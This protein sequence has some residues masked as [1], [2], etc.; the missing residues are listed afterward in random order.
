MR[1]IKPRHRKSQVVKRGINARKRPKSPWIR[2]FFRSLSYIAVLCFSIG[3][4]AWLW[5][6]DWMSGATQSSWQ[7]T[8]SHLGKAGLRVEEV[9]LQGREHE[10]AERITRV[11]GIKRGAPILAINLQD[12]RERLEALSWVR[13]ASVERH[14]PNTVRIKIVERQPMALWQRENKLA[15]ID[16]EGVII[17]R[18]R[19]ERFRHLLVVVGK[20]APAHT[21]SL[22]RTLAKDL[23][24][25]KR[26]AAAVRIG[27]RRWN[28]QMD[29]GI[30]VRLPEEGTEAAWRRF[31]KLERKYELLKQDLLSIDLRMPGQLIV[32]TRGDRPGLNRKVTHRKG[33][34]T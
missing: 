11:I 23:D 3:G 8:F 29:N 10:S 6:S 21:A 13:V 26:V 16:N 5:Q 19:L 14:F 7:A 33:E 18:K 22:I 9:L 2:R 28:I 25:K 24:L 34:S 30:Y 27:D 1:W 15:L 12:V 17:T 32:Q 4:P 31:A 20:T